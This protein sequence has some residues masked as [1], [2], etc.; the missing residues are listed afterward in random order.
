M[1]EISRRRFI[2]RGAAAVAGLGLAGGGIATGRSRAAQGTETDLLIIGAGLAGLS[3]AVTAGELG[4]SAVLADKRYRVGGTGLG[5]GGSF[6]AAGSRMQR[7]K[8]I[9]DSPELHFADAR[10]IGKE[11]N[12]PEILRL[13]T[14]NAG[15]VL[16]W[17]EN[18]G[19]EFDPRGPRMA[20]EHE[21]YSVPRTCDARIGARGYVEVFEKHLERAVASGR[22]RLVTET[23]ATGLVREGE[24]VRGARF[25]DDDGREITIYARAVILATGG[26]GSNQEM[27]RKYNPSLARALKITS[28]YATGEG[29]LM[30]ERV[31]AALVNM[32]LLVPY[33]AGVENPPASG[34]TMF[35]SLISGIVPNFKGDIWVTKEGVRFMNED[36]TSPDERE[37]AL[38][39]VPDTALFA[40][41]DEAMLAA[42]KEPLANFQRHLQEGRV[43]KTAAT[44]AEL[45]RRIGVPEAALES[46]IRTYNGHAA[47]G[48]DP[49]FGRKD[50]VPMEK[51]PFYAIA[52]SGVVFMTMGGV[53]TNAQL[54]VMDTRGH[55]IP[56]LYAAGEV[57]GAGQWMGDGLVGGTGNGAAIVFG[58]LAAR[59]AAAEIAARAGLR[60]P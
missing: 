34:R 11:K 45:A 33:F 43:V 37:R 38:R 44:I 54:Q 40:L 32:D 20:P 27:I 57:Q 48:R 24:R 31:G 42:S 4:V 12:D 3:A 58:R 50:L 53:R 51:P 47:A 23:S 35:N 46:T 2:G 17:L 56:G 26:Y 19:V 10:R 5:A 39:R 22:M 55:P 25:V 13:Y 15:A 9:E 7:A 8:N 29:I 49:A 60:M 14:A 6:S 18:L 1:R 36:S 59:S 21:L 28:K 41:F 52:A 16:D 30:A